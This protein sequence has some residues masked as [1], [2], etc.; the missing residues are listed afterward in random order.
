MYRSSYRRHMSP[1]S[2]A[3]FIL[4]CCLIPVIIYFAVF[5]NPNTLSNSH[6]LQMDYMNKYTEQLNNKN[7]DIIFVRHDPNGPATLNARRVDYLNDLGLQFDTYESCSSHA[8]VLYDLDGML[9]LTAQDLQ[10]IGRLYNEKGFRI[11][12]LGTAHY[13]YLVDAGLCSTLP[14][15]GTQSNIFYRQADGMAVSAPGFADDL[16]KM[17]VSEGISEQQELVYN[18]VMVLST[19]DRYWN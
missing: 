6:E 12:Y 4:A 10:Y 11:I 13:Q 7:V 9:S 15:A 19:E 1:T 14:A 8:L 3:I 17:V 16:S 2:A 18:M 5:A